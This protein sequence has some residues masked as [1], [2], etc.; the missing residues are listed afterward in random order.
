VSRLF[1][2]VFSPLLAGQ[3]GFGDRVAGED[4]MI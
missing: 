3:D 1:D 4:G 2:A